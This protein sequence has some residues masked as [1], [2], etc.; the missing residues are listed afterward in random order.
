MRSYGKIK[1]RS[2][3]GKME[4]QIYMKTEEARMA[5]ILVIMTLALYLFC[6]TTGSDC[7]IAERRTPLPII[8]L[9][10]N[11]REDFFKKNHKIGH[12]DQFVVLF[13]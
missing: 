9:Q 8:I 12:K 2:T 3:I 5:Y 7:R 10:T 11:Y 1:L 6:R 4:R 13:Q